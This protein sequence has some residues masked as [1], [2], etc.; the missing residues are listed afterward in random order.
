MRN[1][2]LVL[3]I[4]I[5]TSFFAEEKLH[6]TPGELETFRGDSNIYR[7][8]VKKVGISTNKLTWVVLKEGEQD[9]DIVSAG[10]GQQVGSYVSAKSLPAETCRYTRI[11]LIEIFT[12]MAQALRVVLLI[13]PLQ[14]RYL[15][16]GVAS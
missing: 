14:T 15:L 7:V 16:L 13:I 2:I 11:T 9:F 10:I 5:I 4:F 3:I 1:C 8:T 12:L 6:A